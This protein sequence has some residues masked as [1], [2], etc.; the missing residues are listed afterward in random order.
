M[1]PVLDKGDNVGYLDSCIA[2]FFISHWMYCTFWSSTHTIHESVSVREAMHG[3]VRTG[4]RDA[5]EAKRRGQGPTPA[6]KDTPIH[7]PVI[8]YYT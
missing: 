2:P 6:A 3:E 8:L 5:A 4:R 7:Q 1:D